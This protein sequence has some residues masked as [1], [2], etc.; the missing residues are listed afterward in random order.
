MLFGVAFSL[1]D[2][3]D[4][5]VMGGLE[6]AELDDCDV[7]IDELNIID[8]DDDDG[9]DEESMGGGRISK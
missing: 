2:P 6:L 5:D 3:L 8:D 7:D 1:D 9:N 4:D